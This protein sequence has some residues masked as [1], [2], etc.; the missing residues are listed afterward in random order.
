MKSGYNWFLHND[1]KSNSNNDDN[2]CQPKYDLVIIDGPK[3]WTIDSSSF[4]LSDK[5]LKDNG[6]I[7]WDDYKWTYSRA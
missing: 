2:I 6:W 7:I 5:L 3:N 4:F 1:I